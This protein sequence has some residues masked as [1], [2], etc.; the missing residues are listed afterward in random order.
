MNSYSDGR[1]SDLHRI[2]GFCDKKN[3]LN[4]ICLFSHKILVFFY[5]H[6]KILQYCIA[7]DVQLAK[8][9]QKYAGFSKFY[10]FLD[11]KRRPNNTYSLEFQ[12]SN[13]VKTIRVDSRTP[14][15]NLRSHISTTHP[16]YLDSFMTLRQSF[17]SISIR[18]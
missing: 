14:K 12:C 8:F 10:H 9:K 15:S 16:E 1:R 11:A 7:D 4:K 5:S 18:S 2:W 13:C 6:L 3:H 17:R